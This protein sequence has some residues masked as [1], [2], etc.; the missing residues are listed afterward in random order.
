MKRSESNLESLKDLMENFSKKLGMDKAIKIST[1]ITMWPEIVGPRFKNNSKAYTLL[2]QNRK[3]ILVVATSSSVVSQELVMFKSEILRNIFK[4]TNKLDLKIH[5]MIFNT[6]IWD[7]LSQKKDAFKENTSVEKYTKYPTD[8][9]LDKINIP[10]NLLTSVIESLQENAFMPEEVK[11]RMLNLV[12]KDTKVQIWKKNNG[13][14]SCS[15][16]GIP[17]SFTNF[18][19]KQILCPACKYL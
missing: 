9:E 10:E 17:V 16:C 14:P 3:N 4:Q 1:L 18:N 12:I 15:R 19:D 7:D 6:K 2:T 11:T 13:F 5:D 8:E